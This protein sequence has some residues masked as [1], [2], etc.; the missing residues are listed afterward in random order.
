M[1]SISNQ[2]SQKWI[3]ILTILTALV[4]ILVISLYIYFIVITVFPSTPLY[5]QET[6]S[7]AEENQSEINSANGSDG[8]IFRNETRNTFGQYADA[9]PFGDFV[10]GLFNPILTFMTILLLVGSVH[11]QLVQ[12][13]LQLKQNLMTLRELK[14]NEKYQANTFSQQESMHLQLTLIDNFK[15]L[16]D[17]I[18]EVRFAVE[19]Y[20]E[21]KFFD[22][23]SSKSRPDRSTEISLY[24]WL[25]GQFKD[26]NP[27]DK[28]FAI[29]FKHKAEY[30]TSLLMIYGE[31]VNKYCSLNCATVLLIELRSKYI[32]VTLTNIYEKYRKL[33]N[34]NGIDE[35]V[36]FALCYEGI[37]ESARKTISN[38]KKHC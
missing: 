33:D 23:F 2:S 32:E 27:N 12:S 21:P 22:F 34:I 31:L 10:G 36:N 18:N 20:E 15:Q 7:Q 29:Y 1:M 37:I 25:N 28:K 6:L 16:E 11:I 3:S 13:K 14:K 5:V 9:G 35:W 4:A 17:V 8:N 24:G 38:R 26:F 30:L 19:L